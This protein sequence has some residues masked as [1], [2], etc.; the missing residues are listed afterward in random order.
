MAW[1][2]GILWFVTGIGVGAV[3]V[4]LALFWLVAQDEKA[5]YHERR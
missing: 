4:I 3:V 1:I 2:W 5:E